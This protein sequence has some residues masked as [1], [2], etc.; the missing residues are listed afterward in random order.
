MIRSV[1]VKICTFLLC[2]KILQK[3]T[4]NTIIF[5]Y[6]FRNKENKEK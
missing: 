3:N 5:A 1:D 4:I 6:S 2:F